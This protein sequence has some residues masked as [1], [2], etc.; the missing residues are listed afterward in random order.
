[1]RAHRRKS[2]TSQSQ[3]LSTDVR[4]EDE[5]IYYDDLK[6]HV[7][8]GQEDT[9]KRWVTR[10]PTGGLAWCVDSWAAAS[11]TGP[12]F[13]FFGVD[14]VAAPIRSLAFLDTGPSSTDG[15][16]SDQW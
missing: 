2:P 8:H 16:S 13:Q 1:M 15:R 11:S 7:C 3:I 5:V 4:G 14:L 6:A 12:K 10:L 9:L